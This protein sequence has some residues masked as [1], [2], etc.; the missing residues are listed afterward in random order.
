MRLAYGGPKRVKRA[1]PAPSYLPH[2]CVC[3][4]VDTAQTS[5]FAVTAGGKVVG[6]GEVDMLAARLPDQDS[7][8]EGACAAALELARLNGLPAVLVFERPFRGT[9]Q[10]AWIGA[11]R[12]AWL[13]AGGRKRAQLGVYPSVW[14]ARALGNGSLPRELARAAEMRVARALVPDRELGGDEAAA[15][16]MSQW[17]IRSGEVG[18]VLPKRKAPSPKTKSPRP[19]QKSLALTDSQTG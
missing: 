16:A 13:S 3:L 4:V 11:W 12:A 15:L 9:S 14:R 6:H 10:G 8:C 2:E 7:P 17:A 5:G 1:K 18:A 19:V